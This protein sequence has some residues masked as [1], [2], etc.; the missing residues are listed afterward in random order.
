MQH[1]NYMQCYSNIILTIAYEHYDEHYI[2]AQI[3]E[4]FQDIY[5]DFI[6]NK[7]FLKFLKIKMMP[8]K[9]GPSGKAKARGAP[10]GRYKILSSQEIARLQ[11]KRQQATTIR[12][13]IQEYSISKATIYRYPRKGLNISS[14][15]IGANLFSYSGLLCGDDPS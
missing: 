12:I 15:C 5:R 8:R 11:A 9:F 4:Y 6:F 10:L 13:L 3:T 2:L 1:H 7:L 14:G